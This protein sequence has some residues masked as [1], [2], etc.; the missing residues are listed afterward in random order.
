MDIFKRHNRSLGLDIWYMR[1]RLDG[2]RH[3]EKIGPVSRK[4]AE[5]FFTNKMKEVHE[6]RILKKAE[7]ILF[8]EFAK[9]YLENYSKPYKKSWRSD[10]N[11]IKNMLRD[12]GGKH[13]DE[14]TRFMV[15]KYRAE[16]VKV[17]SMATI[18]RELTCLK[19]MY[20]KAI[21]WGKL[22]ENPVKGIKFYR[23]ER[24][25][26][27]LLGDGEFQRF[28]SILNGIKTPS[29]LR[30]SCK[31]L[32]FTGMRKGELLGNNGLTWA[33]IDDINRLIVLEKTKS[34][35]RQ[36]VWLND[37]AYEVL[38]S[39]KRTG[40]FVFC[41]DDGSP[42]KNIKT[43]WRT[44]LKRAE[45]ENLRIHDLRHCF[46]S[47]MAMGGANQIEIKEALRHSTLE[48]SARYMHLSNNHLKESVKLVDK[49]VD[50]LVDAPT[51]KGL[52]EVS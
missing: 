22:F 10:E 36:T 50:A 47:Y 52:A 2:V 42:I 41:H 39:L 4:A 35:K 25:V 12:F 45:I 21:E 29:W 33:R 11:S 26:R 31:L 20:N 1:Y 5:I 43:A 37:S 16:R 6:G 44:L 8:K 13:L 19:T 14:I 34:G 51:K 46:A 18:N 30:D 3:Q 32:L 17:V 7:K 9:T 38:R 28:W 27:Y 23:E 49:F 24:R 40:P 48:M 15:E